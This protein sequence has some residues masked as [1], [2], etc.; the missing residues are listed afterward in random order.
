MINK[1]TIQIKTWDG[2]TFKTVSITNDYFQVR[3]AL[4]KQV[5]VF[6]NEEEIIISL[7]PKE[8]NVKKC[9]FQNFNSEE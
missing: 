9:R 7:D 3:T 4:G 6:V 1:T 5:C 8:F 2:Y